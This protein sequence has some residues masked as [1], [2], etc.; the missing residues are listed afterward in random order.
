MTDI[1]VGKATGTLLAMNIAIW[2]LFFIIGNTEMVQIEG[3]FWPARLDAAWFDGADPFPR[4][5]IWLLPVWLTPF[6]AAFLHGGVTHLVMNMLI[7]WY[8][9]KVVEHVIGSGR[10]IALYA[11][12]IV[13]S[14][15]LHFIAERS[16]LVPMV[17]ASG[18]IS[19]VMAFYF[20]LFTRKRP[21]AIG[22]LS[23]LA[24]QML[25]LAVAWT[26]INL[27]TGLAFAQSAFG[28]AIYAHIGGF[29]TGLML[30]K[31]MVSSLHRAEPPVGRR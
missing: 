23:P 4:D 3:G 21:A 10:F 19:A 11:A 30:F 28:V 25:W 14:A 12:G 7:L 9:G 22:P 24:V 1:R 31:P 8:T 17:G 2:A 13:G 27:L 16:D 15:A 18:A 20:L 6:T 29:F 26:A 5:H